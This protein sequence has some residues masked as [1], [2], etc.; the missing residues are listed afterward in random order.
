MKPVTLIQ[1]VLIYL[2][3]AFAVCSTN[4]ATFFVSTCGSNAWAGVQAG[5]AAPLGPKRTIQAAINTANHGDTIIVL[6]GVYV[7]TIDL[8]GKAITLMSSAGP[9]G[10]IIDGGGNGPIVTMNSLEG[11]NTVI[12]GFTIRNGFTN[13]DGGAGM[14]IALATPTVQNCTFESNIAGGATGWGGGI[15]GI[16]SSATISGCRFLNNS[17]SRG[18]GA[19]FLFGQPNIIDCEF[20][21]NQAT[22]FGWG[23]ALYLGSLTGTTISGTL[24][25][26]NTAYDSAGIAAQSSAFTVT[27]CTFT[28]NVGSRRGG[29]IGSLSTVSLAVTGCHFESNVVSNP[30]DSNGGGISVAHGD[31]VILNSTFVNNS[32][33]QFGSA[34][35]AVHHDSL[36]VQNCNFTGNVSNNIGYG[37]ALMISGG[38]ASVLGCNFTGNSGNV[39]AAL[40]ALNSTVTVAWSGFHDNT[41]T[42]TDA[43]GGAIAVGSNGSVV[44]GLSTFIG[45]SSSVRGGAIGIMDGA[46]D[47]QGCVFS[48]NTAPNGGAMCI[49]SGEADLAACTF[50][51]NSASESGGVIRSESTQLNMDNCTFN[52]NNAGQHGG[53]IF[54]VDGHWTA[55]ACVFDSNSTLNLNPPSAG[56]GGAV[57][58]M[59]IDGR[60]DL[61]ECTFSDN[62]A[63]SG[64]AL[65]A[66]AVEFTMHECQFESNHATQGG[67]AALLQAIT[68][69]HVSD[70]S[71]VGNSATNTGGALSM[72]WS[73]QIAVHGSSFVG[74]SAATGGA[75]RSITTGPPVLFSACRFTGNSGTTTGSVLTTQQSA[76]ARLIN[77]VAH[78]NTAA[79][80]GGT[81]YVDGDPVTG[82]SIDLV[83]ST[84]A[85]NF[86]GGIV[87]SMHGSS[88]VRNSILWNNG[89]ASFAGGTVNVH[90]SN[91]PDAASG[92]GNISVNPQFVNAAAGNFR[93]SASSPCIDAGHNWLLPTDTLD[94]NGNGDTTE[95]WPLDFAGNPRVTDN[96]KV[97]LGGCSPIA[98]V[99]DMGAF[100]TAGTPHPV[101]IKL[102]DLNGDGAVDVSDLLL[103][104]ATWGGC[105]MDCCIADLNF[106]GVVDISDLL[107]LLSH[108][109]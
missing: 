27:D 108:W 51:G 18:G 49:D 41:V 90:Y 101:P 76:Q 77:C 43:R 46:I 38:T 84:V 32:A 30:T 86:G 56:Y 68:P 34:V 55:T 65:A 17:A 4:A 22:G 2:A 39:G 85:S 62:S 59:G 23:G 98:A 16:N 28:G 106:D 104:L 10:T 54:G 61:I 5:C 99:V 47:L 73:G 20:E 35:Y 53:A 70:C 102:V 29:A 107:L 37:S 97:N 81:F 93:L 45:N 24:F 31:T 6:P 40:G 42:G 60:L 82:G 57:L 3:I 100:E 96:P 44:A 12:D 7:E 58:H 50:T 11:P 13:T 79:A 88:E 66:A 105:P 19:H 21:D 15:R 36:A 9:A 92:I 87:L 75:A 91:I 83:S 103:L 1:T 89:G 72:T 8:N 74:N 94:I 25:L 33:D 64:G 80:G 95:L 109:G 71:F 69:M 78:N 63:R 52:G 48:A 26:G 67:G 14:F